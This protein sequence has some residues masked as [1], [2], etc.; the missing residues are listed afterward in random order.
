MAAI[1]FM[2]FIN[3]PLFIFQVL[4]VLK[5]NHVI[6]KYD[7]FPKLGNKNFNEEI[8]QVRLPHSDQLLEMK[9]PYKILSHKDGSYSYLFNREDTPCIFFPL[10]IRGELMEKILGASDD[11][12]MHFK[13]YLGAPDEK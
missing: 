4:G 6:K 1:F 11:D 7:T 5:F 9:S 12:L 13:L 3:T 10:G 2:L 8:Y